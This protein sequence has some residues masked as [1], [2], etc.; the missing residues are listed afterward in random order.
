MTQ[1]TFAFQAEI[2]QLLDILVHSLYTEREIFVRELVS[3]AS[4]ALNRVQFELLTNRDVLDPDAELK[5]SITSDEEAGTLT[6]SDT[7]IGMTRED[8][9]GNLG[10]IAKSGAKAFIEAMKEAKDGGASAEVIGQFGVGFYSVFMVAHKVRVVSRS[11]NKDSQAWAWTSDGGDAYTIEEADRTERGTDVI[12]YLNDDAKEFLQS[13]TLKNIVR[14]HSDYIAFP[15]YVGDDE[16]PTNKQTA[17]WRRSASEVEDKEYNDFYKMLTMDFNDPAHRITMRADVPLQFYALLFIP[18]SPEM[19]MFSPRK[20]PG[21]KLYA[22]K[23]LIQDFSKDLLPEYLQFV[24]GV[25]DSEDLPLNVSRESVQ[26]N[27]IM[28]NLKKTLTGKVLSELKRLAQKKQDEY[29]PIFENF[30]RY[31]KQGV[32]V[33]PADRTDIEPLLIFHTTLDDDQEKWYSLDD[34]VERMSENQDDIYYIIGDDFHSARRSPHLDAFRQRGIEVLYMTDPVDNAMLMGLDAYKGHK[35]RNVDEADIDL[36]N[37]G[38][39]KEDETSEQREALNEGAFTTLRDYFTELL[40]KRVRDVRESKTLTGSAARLVSDEAGTGR[41]MFRINRMIDKDYQLPVKI[42]E[43][44]SRHPLM[45]NL[46]QIIERGDNPELANAVAEQVFETAL[47]QDGIHP[48]P[49]SM[50]TRL[51]LLMQA[52]TGSA[53][54]DLD[55]RNTESIIEEPEINEAAGMGGIPGMEGIDIA[56][57]MGDANFADMMDEGDDFNDDKGDTQA[58]PDTQQIEDADFKDVETDPEK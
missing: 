51:T 57:M 11:H 41:N 6:I 33:S 3:N 47:L 48:D 2:K 22:R 49:A 24:Q 40:G 53:V 28:A 27:Q 8:M 36:S 44:N 35:L 1:E 4:D 29:I 17:I 55:Y 45:H 46:E 25:V 13:W 5:I 16:E 7:G 21:L 32:V 52:A 58:F 50:A 42:L 43:L 39:V 37:I 38:T 20:E 10:V 14:K 54:G 34:Y 9:M 56:S 19:T 15:I 12:V 18:G 31:I 30:G 23:V 26:A